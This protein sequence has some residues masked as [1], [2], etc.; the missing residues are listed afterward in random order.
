M[1]HLRK[2]LADDTAHNIPYDEIEV[3]NSLNYVEEPIAI[4]D[5]AEKR[6]HN[7]S[8]PL[9]KIQWNHRKGSEATK[10]ALRTYQVRK[11]EDLAYLPSTHEE[12]P[13]YLSSTQE[14]CSAY[15]TM[16]KVLRTY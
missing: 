13:A 15:L 12:D 4:L 3:D 6:L 2:C 14:E 5:R 7:K 9:V 8:I 10:Q 16:S 1:T 11:K